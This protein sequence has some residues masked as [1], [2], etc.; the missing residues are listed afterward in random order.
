MKQYL[1]L[2]GCLG[3][4]FFAAG[5]KSRSLAGPLSVGLKAYRGEY[6]TYQYPSSA[7]LKVVSPRE[8]VLLGPS[9]GVVGSE[10]DPSVQGESQYAYQMHIQIYDNP[11]QLTPDVWAKD[12]IIN[13]WKRSRD[14]IV[15]YPVTPEGHLIE[16][17]AHFVQMGRE[18]AYMVDMFG[19]DRVVKALYLSKDKVIIE[20]SFV[21]FPI[22]KEPLSLL[23]RDV[24]AL[25]LG[26]MSFVKGS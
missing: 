10:K 3:L 9:I 6:V 23:Q 1:I 25:I 12:H 13:E 26:T 5:C 2:F 24:Y 17:N 11:M 4:L 22:E 21:L 20:I 15:I 7:H 18:R 8:S 16:E 19:F 14:G